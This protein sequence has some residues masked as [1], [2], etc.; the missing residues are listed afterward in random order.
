MN[1]T[2][3]RVLVTGA[4]GFIGS[5]LTEALV[6]AGAEVTAFVHY[7]SNHA[8]GLLS[9][10]EPAIRRSIDVRPGELRD[11]DTVRRAVQGQRYVFH[12][13]A[14]IAIPYSYAHPVD[15]VQTN[16][17]GTLNVLTAARDA[18]VERVVH[19]STSEVYGSAQR[20]PIDEGHPI[21]PQSP[22]AASKAGADALAE[23]FYRSYE[24]PVA[25]IRPFNCYGP[26][27]S[28]RAVIPTIVSQALQ[29][30]QIRIGS[31][32]P[33]R[34]FTYVGD[35]VAGFLAVGAAEA[36]VG[37]VINIGT[38]REISIGALADRIV[39]LTG[40][41]VPITSE[42]TRM[43]PAAS[44]V[45]RLLCDSSLAQRLL[46]WAPAV[47]IDEGLGHVIGFLRERP[48]WTRAGEYEV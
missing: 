47:G 32:T 13:G 42:E 17:D 22:Y 6:R 15:V 5:H 8:E 34:D 27:Q 26:R 24:L 12:L 35:T 30:D 19:T 4:G 48:G 38:G 37:R 10:L 14:L 44:E 3:K 23:A 11:A 2:G 36:A 21:V 16:V 7:R 29:A 9:L 1:W 45:N 41:P 40:R 33:T 20:V 31:L 28:G 46:G 18:G 25:T 39:H 43:R